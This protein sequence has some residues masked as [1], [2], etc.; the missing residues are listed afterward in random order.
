[1]ALSHVL[2]LF[3]FPYVLP[4][5]VPASLPG[6]PD[7]VTLKPEQSLGNG[8]L[9]PQSLSCQSG[10]ISSWPSPYQELNQALFL[11][12]RIHHTTP[13]TSL[14]CLRESLALI[15]E[16]VIA[17]N[18]P[19]M[20]RRKRSGEGGEGSPSCRSAPQTGHLQGAPFPVTPSGCSGERRQEDS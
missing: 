19:L 14:Y 6:I 13:V 9:L 18:Y 20:G 11:F 12:S 15:A 4:S 17:G 5:P 2:L 7:S 16:Q 8:W 10:T 3:F 1:M